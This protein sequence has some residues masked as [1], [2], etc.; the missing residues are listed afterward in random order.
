MTEVN[1]ARTSIHSTRIIAI[2]GLLAAF[3]PVATDMYLPG[4]HQ[5][6]EYFGVSE[7]GIE[8]TLSVFFLGLAL[9]QAVYGPMID[10]WGRRGPLLFG[11]AIYIAASLLCLFTADIGVFT[12]LRFLQAAGG[13]AGMIIGRVIVSDLFDARESARALSMLMA[14][15]TL[16]P[17]LSPILGG[18]IISYMGWKTVFIVM[19]A[20]GLLCFALVWFYIP[21]TLPIARRST[22]RPGDVLRTWAGLLTTPDFIVPALVGGFAQACM[23]AFITGSPSV[24]MTLH[25]VSTQA[26]GW[27]FALIACALVV[28]AQV[29]RVLLRHFQPSVL[30]GGALVLNFVAGLATLAATATGN[31][32]AL[33]IAL[34]LAIGALGMIGA[35]SVAIA[36]AASQSHPGSGSSL[37]GVLQ[38]GFAFLVSSI[39]AALQNGTAWPMSGAIAACGMLASLLWFIHIGRI[40]HSAT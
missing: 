10:R 16:G 11:I 8:V 24:F 4:F 3:A 32:A 25:G 27:L 19:L 23:F 29:N 1:P 36:M 7:G 15:M 28:F 18:V 37:V 22:E 20:F 13:T 40:R 39:V 6:S 26:Y 21:E 34:W 5:M 17:I 9:G 30:M 14:V 33:L 38:F 31:L 2:L 35:N 12:G